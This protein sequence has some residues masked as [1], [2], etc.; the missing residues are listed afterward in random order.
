MRICFLYKN[1]FVGKL[2][3]ASIVC[4]CCVYS[5]TL[6]FIH[7]RSFTVKTT[8]VALSVVAHGVPNRPKRVYSVRSV[9]SHSESVKRSMLR[10]FY[11]SVPHWSGKVLF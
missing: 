8:D 4:A 6:M 3:G 5:Y 11:F 2:S 1:K 7:V 9:R 10:S